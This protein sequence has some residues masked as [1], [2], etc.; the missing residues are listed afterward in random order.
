VETAS[1]D[2][3]SCLQ[4]GEWLP[5]DRA[6]SRLVNDDPQT[7]R[8]LAFDESVRAVTTL[9]EGEWRDKQDIVAENALD[10]TMAVSSAMRLSTRECF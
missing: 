4:R 8:K 9:Y 2:R 1:E 5:S 6:P 3:R 7:N 10:L